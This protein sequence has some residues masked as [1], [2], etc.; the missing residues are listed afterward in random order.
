MKIKNKLGLLQ[1]EV[2]RGENRQGLSR[3]FTVLM[4]RT[5]LHVESFLFGG[6]VWV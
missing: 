3:G 6:I 1:R 5:L 4:L 2:S